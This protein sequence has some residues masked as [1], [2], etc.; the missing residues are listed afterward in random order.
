MGVLLEVAR[1]VIADAEVRLAAP[2]VVL[3]N[4]GEETFL[5]A[6]RPP[7]PRP[8]ALRECGRK[9]HFEQAARRP[10]AWRLGYVYAAAA[11]PL[12]T[13]FIQSAESAEYDENNKNLN[14]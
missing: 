3:L 14:Y 5:Q 9:T 7:L 12:W 10:G 8:D 1:T 6:R 11:R 4:G 13:A 2:L